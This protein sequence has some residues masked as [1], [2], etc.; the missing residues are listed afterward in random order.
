MFSFGCCWVGEGVSWKKK[1]SFVCNGTHSWRACEALGKEL[2]LPCAA[3]GQAVIPSLLCCFFQL[4]TNICRAQG[5][6][7][8][9]RGAFKGRAALGEW[10]PGATRVC[11]TQQGTHRWRHHRGLMLPPRRARGCSGV[12]AP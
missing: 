4:L 7:Q 5:A 9:A 2:Q 12:C 1:K 10:S 3:G 11:P 6:P 8:R